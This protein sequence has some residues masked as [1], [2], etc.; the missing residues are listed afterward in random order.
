MV[1]VVA[2][3]RVLEGYTDQHEENW[4]RQGERLHH[5]PELVERVKSMRYFH[6]LGATGTLKRMLVMEFESLDD[7]KRHDERLAEDEEFVRLHREWTTLVDLSE[8]ELETWEG[9]MQ[10]MWIE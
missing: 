5:N 10:D 9:K 7:M 2:K 1:F 6:G 3:W 4:R 8:R